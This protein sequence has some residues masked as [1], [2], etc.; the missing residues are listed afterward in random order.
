MRHYIYS[1]L[2]TQSNELT[3]RPP[4][5]VQHFRSQRE[6]TSTQERCMSYICYWFG[7]I[8]RLSQLGGGGKFPLS[9]YFYPQSTLRL[10]EGGGGV[11]HPVARA[12]QCQINFFKWVGKNMCSSPRLQRIQS[13]N[14]CRPRIRRISPGWKPTRREIRNSCQASTLRTTSSSSSL[15]HRYLRK[16]STDSSPSCKALNNHVQTMD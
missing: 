7:N 5:L 13:N 14:F 1:R 10:A 8:S 16:I 4:E 9:N 3:R 6:F 15:S 11:W 2:E 12:S